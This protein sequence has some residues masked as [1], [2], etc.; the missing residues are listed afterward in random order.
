MKKLVHNIG[1][2]VGI[3]PEGKHLL[4]GNEMDT[5]ESLDNAFLIINNGIIERFGKEE[6]VVRLEETFDETIDAEGGYVMP[7]FCDSHTHVVLS[8]IHI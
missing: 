1:K 5:V 7:T 4:A 8:L 2:L 3:L 6:E